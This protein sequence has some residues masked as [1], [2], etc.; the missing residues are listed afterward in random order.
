M[1]K[2]DRKPNGLKDYWSLGTRKNGLERLKVE[3]EKEAGRLVLRLWK[4]LVLLVMPSKVSVTAGSM[5]G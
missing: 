3:M 4:G 1:E 2:M 5:N